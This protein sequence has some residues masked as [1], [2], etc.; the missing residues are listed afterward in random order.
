VSS[1]NVG[2]QSI[3]WRYN[4][5]LVGSDLAQVNAGVMY[6]GVYSGLVP[7]PAGAIITFTP[8]TVLVYDGTDFGQADAKLVKIA[9]Q[10]SFNHTATVGA[11]YVVVR[12]TWTD[13]L[14]WYADIISTN[15]VLASDVILC[16][17]EWNGSVVSRVDVASHTKGFNVDFDAIVKNLLPLASPSVDRTVMVSAGSF[18]YGKNHVTYAG[19][20]V[21]LA[22]AVHANGRYD[23]VGLDTLGALVVKSGA[24]GGGPPDLGA[25]LPV[26][27]VLVR[28]GVGT[29]LQIDI[30]DIRPHLT[31]SGVMPDSAVLVDPTGKVLVPGTVAWLSDFVTWV[32]SAL[33]G[34]L[35]VNAAALS[36]AVKETSLT[37]SA[38]N[39]PTSAAVKAYV[40]DQVSCSAATQEANAVSKSDTQYT[41][42]LALTSFLLNKD[43]G[44]VAAFSVAM[45]AASG[46][47]RAD[48]AV[49]DTATKPWASVLVTR[50]KA[51][52]GAD[53]GHPFYMVGATQA[54]LPDL[55]DRY[56]KDVGLSGL[57][58]GEKVNADLPLHTHGITVSPSSPDAHTHT[59]NHRHSFVSLKTA[60]SSGG[61]EIS[62]TSPP[63]GHTV[64]M[65]AHSHAL[66][67]LDHTHG[68][69][70]TV[71]TDGAGETRFTAGAATTRPTSKAL[72]EG[73]LTGKS[74]VGATDTV[75]TVSPASPSSTGFLPPHDHD[76]PD[77]ET[78][79]GATGSAAPNT[80]AH[81]AIAADA[82]TAAGMDVDHTVL[83]YYIFAGYP[84][85]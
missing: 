62:V 34:G 6:P 71:G 78:Y 39:I 48:G 66:P 72:P 54:R 84:G 21:Q 46:W 40:D 70:G 22:A 25:F 52:A 33:N 49:V 11:R 58:L 59:M 47:L 7:S 76:I 74:T 65:N 60:N 3:L 63:H 8:G 57:D 9:F 31:F 16:A 83:R 79:N 56:A 13:A 81:A 68:V 77:T 45:D 29:L 51:E 53:T 4:T 20:S 18:V 43:I 14:S 2:A 19:G 12:Y 36:G 38:T 85:A 26:A 15:T 50:L 5:P 41:G 73:C 35:V 24:E 80:H 69:I 27:M 28:N 10:T 64:T 75:S 44:K 32:D 1:S 30:L 23:C 55:R 82:G 42:A 67:D 61:I 37:D 17:L